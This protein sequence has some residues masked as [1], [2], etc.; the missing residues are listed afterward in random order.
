MTDVRFLHTADGGEIEFVNGVVTLDDG[1]LTAAYLSMFGGNAQ[2]SGL[3]ADDRK[4]WWGN[5]GEPDPARRY[6]SETQ[7]L[8]RSIP[9]TSNNLKRVQAA[10]ERD[11]AWMVE[12]DIA[13]TVSVRVTIPALNR[14]RIAGNIVVAD[15]AYPFAFSNEWRAV[16]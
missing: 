10:A 12:E 7:H 4:Q 15:S 14:V 11:L 13:S 1:L 9:A 8:L 2:D 3:A 5:L 6:R 16:P